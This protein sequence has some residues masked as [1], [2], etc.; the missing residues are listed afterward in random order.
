M[1]F[2]NTYGG[3]N[4][5]LKHIK[6]DY[7]LPSITFTDSNGAA[8]AATGLDAIIMKIWSSPSRETLLAT[9]TEADGISYNSITGVMTFAVA[10]ASINLTL[11]DKYYEIYWSS[12]NKRTGAYG[13]FRVI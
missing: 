11:G 8:Y 9:I 7:F 13:I 4:L 12:P 6:E 5:N 10:W 3:D 2:N 1:S